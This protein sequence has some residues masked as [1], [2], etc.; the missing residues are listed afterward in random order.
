MY[1]VNKKVY[2]ILKME[3]PRV[4]KK[5]LLNYRYYFRKKHLL[6]PRIFIIIH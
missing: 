4:K 3:I 6:H 1:D 2:S 5:N